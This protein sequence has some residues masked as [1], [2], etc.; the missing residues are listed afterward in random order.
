[1]VLIDFKYY[2]LI[3]QLVLI[4]ISFL[5][6]LHYFRFLAHCWFTMFYPVQ[7]T[8]LTGSYLFLSYLQLYV[9]IIPN[10]ISTCCSIK[11]ILDKFVQKKCILIRQGKRPL[12]LEAQN[13]II[14]YQC[15]ELH[16]LD[17][18]ASILPQFCPHSVL[19]YGQKYIILAKG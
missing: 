6:Q 15:C 4:F 16:E 14:C 11:Y 9:P 19:S 1:M 5:V 7:L 12:G 2:Y 13:L 18:S 8:F 10:K 17:L 3:S